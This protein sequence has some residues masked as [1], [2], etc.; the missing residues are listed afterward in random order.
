MGSEEMMLVGL[1]AV[2]VSMVVAVARPEVL[3]VGI[4]SLAFLG[5]AARHQLA[6]LF[7]MFAAH[8]NAAQDAVAVHLSSVRCN[9]IVWVR[10]FTEPM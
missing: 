6:T 9:V 1:G 2:A 10:E 8:V 5:A 3:F 4:V 7:G